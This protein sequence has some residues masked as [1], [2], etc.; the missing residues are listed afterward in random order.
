MSIAVPRVRAGYTVDFRLGGEAATLTASALPDGRLG[1]VALR[2]GKHGSTLSGMTEAFA[3]AMSVALLH[4]APLGVLAD[5]MRGRRF[6][7]AGHTD[8]EEVGRASSLA[9][10]VACRLT[11]DFPAE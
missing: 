10:Y 5:E 9:D 4:G 3:T 7:P 6:A 1:D 2:A 11:A 8:D